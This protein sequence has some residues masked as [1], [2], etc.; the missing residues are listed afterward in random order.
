[1]KAYCFFT[2]LLFYL[3]LFGQ[4]MTERQD[5]CNPENHANVEKVNKKGQIVSMVFYNLENL[6]DT[7]DDTTTLDEEFTS[8]GAKRW[9]YGKFL[10]KLNHV[11]KTILAIGGWDPPAVIGMCEVEN[12]FVLNKLIYETP[13]KK[14]KYRF[15]HFESP[16]ARGIDV[17]L[18]YRPELLRVLYSKNIRIRFPFD[19]MMHTR[20]ILH[21]K[22]ILFEADTVN[23]F[24]NH[25]PSR[26][27][28]FSASV[29]K[30]LLVA[31]KLRILVDSL[32][33]DNPES[34]IIIMGDFNDEPDQPSISE[35][36]HATG[37]SPQTRSDSLV[38]LMIPKMRNRTSGTHKYQGKWAI[39][40][41]FMVSGGL[42]LNQKGLRTSPESVRIF[43]ADF[44]S[45][46]DERFFG[47]KPRRTYSGPRY[48]GG[49]SDHLPI[50]LEVWDAEK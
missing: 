14:F 46:E 6:Y 45:E 23:I 32:F 19:T 8:G 42:L 49:F 28:G 47:T 2:F 29:P 16:D 31:G 41:Q 9:T 36:L 27:G 11:A 34:N 26:R 4:Y 30:R 24:V 40:D 5:S 35:V 1:M 33:Q 50:C 10:L 18:L 17:A 20:D 37:F 3:P 48:T 44:L 25:W 15:I 22:G 43:N 12:R 7:Y 21:V 39:L 38:N 13:L